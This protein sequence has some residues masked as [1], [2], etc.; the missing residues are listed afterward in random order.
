MNILVSGGAG[1]IGYHLIKKLKKNN[2]VFSIDRKGTNIVKGIH[3]YRYNI[4]DSTVEKIIKNEKPDCIFHLAAN[5]DISKNDYLIDIRDTL[6][7]TQLLLSICYELNIK[8]FIFASSSAIYGESNNLLDED[9]G[10]L[11]PISYYGAAKLASEAF[12]SAFS[13]R[14]NIQSWICRF[15]NVVGSCATHGV[16][17]DFVNKLKTD[18]VL[19]VLGNGNQRKPYLHVSELINAML[20]IWQNSHDQVNVFNIGPEDTISVKE[21]A[22]MVTQGEIKY[23]DSDRGWPGDCP[24]FEYDTTKLKNLG[25]YPKL[26]S[27]EAVQLAIK[28]CY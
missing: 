16:I 8:Q 24:F 17:Y 13:F 4:Q 12:I 9:S 20:F 3:Y 26:T 27:R 22:E 7:T 25:W 18:K 11:L 1:F 21:I 14:N 15:P 23:T 19:N 6:H 2:H 10:P 5:S 28:E